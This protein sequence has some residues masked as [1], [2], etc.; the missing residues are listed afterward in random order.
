MRPRPDTHALSSIYTPVH[1]SPWPINRSSLS[2][3]SLLAATAEPS[4]AIL[5]QIHRC[6]PATSIHQI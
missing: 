1:S 4:D 2:T 5:R 3:H 6:S